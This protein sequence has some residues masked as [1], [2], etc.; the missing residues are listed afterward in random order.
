MAL[1][2]RSQ[3]GSRGGLN[4]STKGLRLESSAPTEAY[5]RNLRRCQCHTTVPCTYA[6][7]CMILRTKFQF[8][9]GII[10]QIPNAGE[11]DSSMHVF[12]AEPPPPLAFFWPPVCSDVICLFVR[13]SP[14]KFMKSFARWQH[15]AASGRLSYRLPYILVTTV[16]LFNN[17]I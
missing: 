10:P 3:Q 6:Q 15:L 13:L 1:Q 8:F 4:P 9:P 5:S 12:G 17:I 11:G 7:N 14:V 16:R 2:A